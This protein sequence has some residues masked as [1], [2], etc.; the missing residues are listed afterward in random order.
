MIGKHRARS[1]V[2]SVSAAVVAFA[3]AATTFAVAESGASAANYDA[4]CTAAAVNITAPNPPVRIAWA[5][6]QLS[7]CV[8][9]V[10]TVLAATAT[11][12]PAP[13]GIG[14]TKLSVSAVTSRTFEGWTQ[15]GY[16]I[17]SSSD[18]AKLTLTGPGLNV[19]ATGVHSDVTL[20]EGEGILTTANSWIASLKVNGVAV[21][22]LKNTPITI[23]LGLR[24]AIYLNYRNVQYGYGHAL[25]VGISFPD[26]RY[27]VTVADSV[28]FQDFID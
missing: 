20:T 21:N 2:R 23:P 19:V 8:S 9:D 26:P 10:K 28:A 25:P 27:Y 15:Y 6:P 22:V 17:K 4:G 13:L 16:Q 24:T 11:V 18:I 7:P 1:V 3:A 14:A 5:N 12:I